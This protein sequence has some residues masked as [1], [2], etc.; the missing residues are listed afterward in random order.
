LSFFFLLLCWLFDF[1]PF[2]VRFSVCFDVSVFARLFVSFVFL[3]VCLGRVAFCFL[4]ALIL[5]YCVG[6][7][8]WGRLW[9]MCGFG[10]LSNFGIIVFRFVRC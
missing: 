2:V 4:K 10:A 8:L 7:M 5:C 9:C 3:I 6:I 1:V